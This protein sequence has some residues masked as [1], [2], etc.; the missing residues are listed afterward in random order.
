VR[1]EGSDGLL[2]RRFHTGLCSD[3]TG[4]VDRRRLEHRSQP[5]KLCLVTQTGTRRF[6]CGE[7]EL[8]RA[9]QL[10]ETRTAKRRAAQYCLEIPG[11][12]SPPR[13]TG[14]RSVCAEDDAA[15]EDVRSPREYAPEVISAV[16]PAPRQCIEGSVY[17][18][19]LSTRGEQLE[20]RDRARAG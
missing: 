8:V 9:R 1:I 12:V 19:G 6:E 20:E 2:H 10:D 5:R 13:T 17:R 11:S 15:V 16:S 7:Y 3:E 14:K 4:V 18:G